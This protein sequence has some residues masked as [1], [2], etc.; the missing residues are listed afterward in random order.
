MKINSLKIIIALL[1][2]LLWLSTFS[3][4]KTSTI[5]LKNQGAVMTT[6]EVPEF[7]FYV[8]D[9]ASAARFGL[10]KGNQSIWLSALKSVCKPEGKGLKYTL[11]GKFLEKGKLAF[12]VLPLYQTDGVIIRVNG[13]N[14]PDS[15]S[16]FWAFGAACGKTQKE[17]QNG[18]KPSDCKNNVFVVE[19]NGV[20]L[21][22]PKGGLHD[23][24]VFYTMFPIETSAVL[25]DAHK[26]NSPLELFHS[27]HRT[28][29]QALSGMFPIKNG[30]NYYCSFYKPAS[31]YDVNYYRLPAVFEETKVGK[32]QDH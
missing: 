4:I 20:I 9:K 31:N 17:V 24:S 6:G 3:Q 32:P 11:T 23:F 1:L 12:E 18:L 2:P 15:L 14:L 5:S 16:L 29:A 8:P 7:T 28:D 27:G 13:E 19:R 25:S 10:V 21:Y 30:Q 26:Q 22:Y